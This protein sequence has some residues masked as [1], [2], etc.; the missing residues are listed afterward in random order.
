MHAEKRMRVDLSDVHSSYL[1]GSIV[2][3]RRLIGFCIGSS[4]KN[5]SPLKE[6]IATQR[7]DDILEEKWMA[8]LQNL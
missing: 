5:Y 8:I 7:R 3:S 2:T 4:S 1:H 6:I